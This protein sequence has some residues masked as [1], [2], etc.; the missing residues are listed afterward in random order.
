[1]R[2]NLL[3]FLF[4]VVL[5][6][7]ELGAC[8]TGIL[9]ADSVVLVEPRAAEARPGESPRGYR[10]ST[11]C[12]LVLIPVT[13]TDPFNHFITGL[14]RQSFQLFEEN[15]PQEILS[16]SGED[17]P[18]SVGLVLDWSG[19][20]KDKFAKSQQAVAAFLRLSNPRDEFLLMRFN[21]TANLAQTFTTNSREIQ[22]SLTSTQPSGSTALLDSLYRAIQLMKK[23]HNPR[24]ALLLISD[25][26]DNHSRYSERDI[27]NLIRESDVQVYAIGIYGS[28]AERLRLPELLRGPRLMRWVAK[29]SGGRHYA[30]RDVNSLADVSAKIGLELRNQYILGYSPREQHL[31]GRYRRVQVKV[32]PPSGWPPLRASWKSG[33]YVPSN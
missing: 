22:N 7:S 4:S 26:G 6:L 27:K 19:S 25:G 5:R 20:M 12:T 21:D 2:A 31:D 11:Q 3:P 17:A 30:V 14:Q 23:A 15:E 9:S 16:F 1:M 24:K 33:Y 8:P 18:V 29:E 32:N 13:V 10:I 28:G